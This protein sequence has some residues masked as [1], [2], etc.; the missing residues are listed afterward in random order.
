MNQPNKSIEKSYS[1]A[2]GYSFFYSFFLGYSFFF[3]AAGAGA[4]D[5]PAGAPSDTLDNPLL[6]NSS[7]FLFPMDLRMAST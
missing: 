7:T 2:G 1:S 6:I 3:S 4:E 5:P